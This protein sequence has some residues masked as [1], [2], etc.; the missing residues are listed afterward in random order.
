M[1]KLSEHVILMQVGWS[2]QTVGETDVSN[3][4]PGSCSSC[5]VQVLLFKELNFWNSCPAPQI[6]ESS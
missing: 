5:V 4:S 1:A 3:M 2:I 6:L